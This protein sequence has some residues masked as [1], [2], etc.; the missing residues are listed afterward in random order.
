MKKLIQQIAIQA[1]LIL[2]IILTVINTSKAQSRVNDGQFTVVNNSTQVI[3]YPDYIS[4]Y[5]PST[6]IPDSVI[7]IAKPHIKAVGRE[8][9]FH[10]TGGRINE[11]K[12]YAHSGFDIGHNCDASDE[13]GN[14]TDEY[15]SFDFCNTFPQRPN[16]NRITWLALESYTRALKQSVRVK[17]SWNGIQSNIGRDKI[18]VP[19]YCIK[20]LWYNKH[21]EKYIIPN[22]DT[23]I[24]HN[25]LYYKIK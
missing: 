22:Q 25:F 24:K 9:G 1:I 2:I 17:V 11:D 20:E 19:L 13:N 18:I 21:Y 16:C 14:K 12:D 3:T 15:N 7:W 4:Y 5:N 6:L 10:A 23:C 8:A